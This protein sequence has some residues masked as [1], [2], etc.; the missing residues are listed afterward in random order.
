[1]LATVAPLPANHTFDSDLL[2]GTARRQKKL[3]GNI[4]GKLQRDGK[5]FVLPERFAA[6]KQEICKDPELYLA[7]WRSVLQEL[8]KEVAVIAQKGS[9]VSIQLLFSSTTY[10]L[11]A[12]CIGCASVL[13]L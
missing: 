6:L 10:I 5:G 13:V 1:M 4:A 9:N 8:E 7:R 11:T 3:G 12:I 2:P